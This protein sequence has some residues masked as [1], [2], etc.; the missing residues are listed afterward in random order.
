MGFRN[1]KFQSGTI[2]DTAPAELLQIN[3]D[4]QVDERNANSGQVV[5]KLTQL[6]AVTQEF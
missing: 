5:I 1:C 6:G 3:S 2:G 4:L